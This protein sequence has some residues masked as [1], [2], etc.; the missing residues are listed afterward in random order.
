[1][2]IIHK[3][4]PVVQQTETVNS[5]LPLS[6]R[7]KVVQVLSTLTTDIPG[8]GSAL[9]QLSAVDTGAAGRGGRPAQSAVT[10]T[11]DGL[12]EAARSDVDRTLVGGVPITFSWGLVGQGQVGLG[13]VDLLGLVGAVLVDDGLDRCQWIVALSMQLRAD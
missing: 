1:M 3:M 13:L 10:L 7:R 4:D 8:R 2:I 9:V 11:G 6:I 5:L 12:F